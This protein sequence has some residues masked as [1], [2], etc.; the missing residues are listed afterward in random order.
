MAIFNT[1]SYLNWGEVTH[2]GK[3][4]D[5]FIDMTKVVMTEDGISM[6][7][8]FPARGRPEI[9]HVVTPIER[10]TNTHFLFMYGTGDMNTTYEH[11][12]IL[13]DRLA[14]HGKYNFKVIYCYYMVSKYLFFG[15]K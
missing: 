6:C 2:K 8:T 14:R 12:Y 4:M 11:G 5:K 9:E 15:F 10:A 7:E 1:S 3:V 13:A